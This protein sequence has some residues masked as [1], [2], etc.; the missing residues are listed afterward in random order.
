MGSW[1]FG[2]AA[3]FLGCSPWL[4]GRIACWWRKEVRIGTLRGRFADTREK[5]RSTCKRHAVSAACV[6]NCS[7]LGW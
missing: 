3:D 2:E 6:V 4:V 5:E 7:S 1:G